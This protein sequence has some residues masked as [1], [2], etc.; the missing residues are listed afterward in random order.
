MPE[1]SPLYIPVILGTLRRGR[2]S[3]YAARVVLEQVASWPGVTSEIIDIRTVPLP[4]DDEGQAIKDPGFAEQMT[5]AD[6]LIIVSPEYNHGYPGM[7]KH[8]L[9]SCLKEYVH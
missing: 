1:A 2:R 7:L 3:E 4:V 9:D 8:V 6:A 5:R